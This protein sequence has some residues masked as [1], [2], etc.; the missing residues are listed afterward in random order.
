MTGFP[1]RPL[2]GFNFT[3]SLLE[4]SDSANGAAIGE[5]V[6]TTS[7]IRATAGFTE[8]SG[9]EMRMNVEEYQAGGLNNGAL[10]FVGPVSWPNIILKRGVVYRRDPLDRTD[11]WA[12]CQEFLDGAGIRRDGV[13]TLNDQSGTARRAW[14]FSRGIPMHWSGPS[15]DAGQS[16]VAME[17]IEIAHEGLSDISGGTGVGALVGKAVDFVTD[18]LF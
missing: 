12:W 10:K 7:G 13:I 18:A 2:T 17:S 6:L 16:L 14:S 1:S 8:A 9:L 5:V 11:L 15:F 4:S 3:V